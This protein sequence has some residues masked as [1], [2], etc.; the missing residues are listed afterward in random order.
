M[1][2]TRTPSPDRRL[3]RASVNYVAAKWLA[4]SY[5]S[6]RLVITVNIDLTTLPND[7]G[8]KNQKGEVIKVKKLKELSVESWA[9]VAHDSL[10]LENEEGSALSPQRLL[11]F[12]NRIISAKGEIA[13]PKHLAAEYYA[14]EQGPL[15]GSTRT[16]QVFAIHDPYKVFSESDTPT[17]PTAPTAPTTPGE[18]TPNMLS[19]NCPAP[20]TDSP[21]NTDSPDPDGPDGPDPD[22]P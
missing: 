6:V 19:P 20:D 16:R 22:G 12:K 10:L 2:S 11:E 1:R 15:A 4:G 14:V 8:L 18:L 7:Q 21:P 5:G 9:S 13:N 17:A 3:S